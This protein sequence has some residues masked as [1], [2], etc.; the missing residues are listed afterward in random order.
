MAKRGRP[1]TT[2][3]FSVQYPLGIHCGARLLSIGGPV[4]PER[5]PHHHHHYHRLYSILDMSHHCIASVPQHYAGLPLEFVSLSLMLPHAG[6]PGSYCMISLYIIPPRRSAG[7]LCWD[8]DYLTQ[9]AWRLYKS[10]FF[11]NLVGWESL[12]TKM[13][14]FENPLLYFFIFV[15]RS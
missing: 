5:Y 10:L 9:K 15:G 12:T 14:R 7:F 2:T 3:Q 6:V 11:T 4:F 8:A 1:F 13:M